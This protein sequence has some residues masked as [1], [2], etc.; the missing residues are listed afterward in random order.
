MPIS[1]EFDLKTGE[2]KIEAPG[3]KF[4]SCEQAT[5]FLRD[6]L[7]QVTA[8]QKKSEYF[9]ASLELT[10]TDRVPAT[11]FFGSS[12]LYDK[13]Q[14]LLF[15]PWCCRFRLSRGF[16]ILPHLVPPRALFVLLRGIGS[17]RT[18]GQG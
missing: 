10:G 17:S 7:R 1:S 13:I 4:G 12:E 15:F 5:K 6:T 11:R 14:H 3:F 16:G 18:T 8:F 9:E 2:A